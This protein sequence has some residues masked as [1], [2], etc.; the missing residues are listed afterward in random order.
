MLLA[1]KIDDALKEKGWKKKDLIEALWK[2]NK[3]KVTKLLSGTH[4]FTSNL[5]TDLGRVLNTNFFNLEN[6]Q[7]RLTVSYK[8][9][10]PLSCFI[11]I[12]I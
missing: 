3:S 12:I 7:K 10:Q 8:S 2:K 11:V 6:D 5:L 1:V 9:S 4:N